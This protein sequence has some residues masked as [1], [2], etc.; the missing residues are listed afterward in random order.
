MACELHIVTLDTDAAP[1]EQ[2]ITFDDA[3]FNPKACIV[4]NTAGTSANTVQNTSQWGRGFWAEGDQQHTY[5]GQKGDFN[6]GQAYRLNQSGSVHK[7]CDTGTGAVLSEFNI[8]SVVAGTCT[9]EITTQNSNGTIFLFFFIDAE[10]ACV[11][12][13]ITPDSTG[14]DTITHANLDFTPNCIFFAGDRNDALDEVELTHTLS[15]MGFSSG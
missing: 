7:H 11:G 10:E 1:H 3:S 4:I 6:N 13:D 2:E 8:K 12:T 5:G 14:N 9:I 15:F